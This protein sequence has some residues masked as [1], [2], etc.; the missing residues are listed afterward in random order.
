MKIQTLVEVIQQ[1]NDEGETIKQFRILGNYLSEQRALRVLEDLEVREYRRQTKDPE[2][3]PRIFKINAHTV[4][5][6][7]SKS[8]IKTWK[9]LERKKNR[10]KVAK[11]RNI[12]VD[13][14]LNE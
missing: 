4:F 9:E 13:E 1:V 11:F 7:S 3:K 2:Y 6:A 10:E 12:V 5:G 14:P 8:A